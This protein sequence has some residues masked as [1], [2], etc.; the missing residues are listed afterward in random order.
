MMSTRPHATK[1]KP[2][3]AVKSAMD[4]VA[5]MDAVPAKMAKVATPMPLAKTPNKRS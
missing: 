1:V 3:R 2:V 4:V 5:A